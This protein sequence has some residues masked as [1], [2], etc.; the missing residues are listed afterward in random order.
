MLIDVVRC[1]GS[2]F[3]EPIV[4]IQS[5]LINC[6]E[7]VN[8]LQAKDADDAWLGRNLTSAVSAITCELAEAILLCQKEENKIKELLLARLNWMF[9]CGW[10]AV[11]DGDISSIV[12]HVNLETASRDLP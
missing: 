11:L 10:A 2:A 4:E 8:Q 7:F 5:E 9:C 12:E 1:K 3:E 6:L